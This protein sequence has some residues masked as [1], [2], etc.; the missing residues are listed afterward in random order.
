[1]R[2]TGYGLRATLVAALLCSGCTG[3]LLDSDLPAATSYIIAPAPGGSGSGPIVS[4][5]LS[6]GRPDVAPGLDTQRIAVLKGREL[7]YYR[8]ATWGGTTTEV[9]Q[10]FLVS[11]FEDQHLFRSVST[12][13][14][15]VSGAYV[16][17]IEVRDFQ[18]EY[19]SE[20]TPPTAHVTLLGRLIRVKDRKL[21]AALNATAEDRAN[22]NRLGAV[23]G[24]FEKAAQKVAL[25]LAQKVAA[26]VSS[27]VPEQK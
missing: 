24:S 12:E 27:D 25:D 4:V 20:G 13:Q 22:D 5:D 21:I 26:A 15:R 11:S 14:A 1:M 9:I 10:T 8:A 17:D 7:D 19:A 18:A 2:A 23:V 6:I 3:S 16:L